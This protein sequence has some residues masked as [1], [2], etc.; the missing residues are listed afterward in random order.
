MILT[1][2]YAIHEQVLPPKSFNSSSSRRCKKFYIAVAVAVVVVVDDDDDDDGSL[3]S[4]P[5]R[6]GR[7]EMRTIADDSSIYLT[8]GHELIFTKIQPIMISE[9]YWVV[10]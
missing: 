6:L 7:R 2:I 1:K 9:Q 3:L 10:S 4:I 8:V 5:W